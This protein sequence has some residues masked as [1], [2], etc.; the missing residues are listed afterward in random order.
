MT[1]VKTKGW[2]TWVSFFSSGRSLV[3]ENTQKDEIK[4]ILNHQIEIEKVVRRGGK[5]RGGG[6]KGGGG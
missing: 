3:G 6:G 2:V 5:G 1:G 4:T